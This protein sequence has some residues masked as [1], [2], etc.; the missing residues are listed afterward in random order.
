MVSHP[1]LNPGEVVSDPCSSHSSSLNYFSCVH[2]H[3]VN[4]VNIVYFCLIN[5]CRKS[6]VQSYWLL[7]L[8]CFA[9]R[10][11]NWEL[12]SHHH[13]RYINDIISGSQSGLLCDPSHS[14]D[15]CRVPAIFLHSSTNSPLMSGN[16]KF[17]SFWFHRS[18]LCSNRLGTFGFSFLLRQHFLYNYNFGVIITVFLCLSCYFSPQL[19]IF[20]PIKLWLFGK[21]NYNLFSSLK[22]TCF[23]MEFVTLMGFYSPGGVST[24]Q[25]LQNH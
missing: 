9:E 20:F 1:V 13:Q 11:P 22:I 3:V 2:V 18:S 19:S 24:I 23:L 21:K 12:W 25:K 5:C 14:C 7:P 4:F 17:F 16:C 6:K 8:K 15:S 10:L